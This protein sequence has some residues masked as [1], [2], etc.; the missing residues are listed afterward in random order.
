MIWHLESLNLKPLLRPSI[1]GGMPS[2]HTHVYSN[3]NF[4]CTLRDT[5]KRIFSY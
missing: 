2:K 5:Y 4:K 1:V 3:L